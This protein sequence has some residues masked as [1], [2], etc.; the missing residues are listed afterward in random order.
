MKKR[1]RTLRSRFLLFFLMAALP[2][3]LLLLYDNFYSQKVT[4]QQIRQNTELMMKSYANQTDASMEA[5]Q[6]GMQNIIL[7]DDEVANMQYLKSKDRTF[8]RITVYNRL[9]NLLIQQPMLS[10][11]FLY[12]FYSKDFLNSSR[13]DIN[14]Q[15]YTIM[16][17]KVSEWL[18]GFEHGAKSMSGWQIY[19]MEGENYL[20]YY[21]YSDDV[22]LGGLINCDDIIASAKEEMKEEEII[23]CY[24]GTSVTDLKEELR[25][26]H[27]FAAGTKHIQGGR[28][29][30]MENKLE[31]PGFS[32]V[33]IK[34][35]ISIFRQMPMLQL[36]IILTF[37][38]YVIMLIFYF[39]GF[40][41]LVVKPLYRLIHTMNRISEGD[42]EARADLKSSAEEYSII[43][44]TF[45]NM[46]QRITVLTQD[47]HE[48]EMKQK[49]AQL[50][51]L[52]MQINPHFLMNSL[53]IIYTAAISKNYETVQEMST[54]LAN[55]FRYSLLMQEETVPLK[56]ELAFVKNYLH[57][58]EIRFP[59]RFEYEINSPVYLQTMPI[60]PMI[61]K[62]FA[63]NFIK[64]VVSK[65]E[66]VQLRI[67][68][69]LKSCEEGDKSFLN[70]KVQDNGQGFPKEVLEMLEKGEMPVYDDSIHTGIWN[71]CQRLK[72]QYNEEA[73]VKLDNLETGGAIIQISLPVSVKG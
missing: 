41:H 23:F 19:R 69:I 5:I 42:L 45:N 29:L 18:D 47:V 25:S 26:L 66:F 8:A 50:Q 65:Q 71:A 55:Y 27:P 17:Q 2:I 67:D 59:N 44:N 38:L 40:N 37:F 9:N 57:I 70:I 54:Y 49:R 72:L 58:Q 61:I 34:K 39:L 68:V 11:S 16:E 14:Y 28:Y 12:S 60:P 32:I 13:T 36:L 51:V 4:E 35:L 30:V 56:E 3:I 15:K 48:K 52:Q 24:Q 1:C 73:I 63:E 64:Y 21:Y 62:E 22:C 43:S 20:L 46:L 6:K 7:M 31:I 53:N 33:T 10:M